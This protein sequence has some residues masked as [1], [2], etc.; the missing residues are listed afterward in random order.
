[1]PILT[2]TQVDNFNNE[3]IFT[4]SDFFD[5]EK[6]TLLKVKGIGEKTIIKIE[7]ALNDYIDSTKAKESK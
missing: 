1:M 2:E 7:K 5:A 3:E 4:T 6:K